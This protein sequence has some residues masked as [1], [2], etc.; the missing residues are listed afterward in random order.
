MLLVL[1]LDMALPK[2]HRVNRKRKRG[3]PS[4]PRLAWPKCEFPMWGVSMWGPL[5][6]VLYIDVGLLLGE[7]KDMGAGVPSS[8]PGATPTAPGMAYAKLREDIARRLRTDRMLSPIWCIMPIVGIVVLFVMLFLGVI[9]ATATYHPTPAYYS[10]Q[11]YYLTETM[12]ILLTFVV[13]GVIIYGILWIYPIYVLITRRNLHFRRV[14]DLYADVVEVLRDI[15]TKTRVDVSG[16]IIL[17]ERYLGEMRM[18]EK[19]KSAA[20]WIILMF[21]PIVNIFAELYVLYFLTKDWYHHERREDEIWAQV[22]QALT[23]MGYWP[24]DIRRPEPIPSRSFFLYFILSLLTGIWTIYWLYVLI[25]DPNNHF[26]SHV[27]AEDDLLTALETGPTR[28][29]M[30]PTAP[31]PA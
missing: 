30:T 22:N 18:E 3:L 19:E 31:G 24:I 14:Q 17:I 5:P 21:I 28:A 16:N 6:K 10:A 29:P 9:M 4:F 27:R 12:S 25:K 23:R 15:S 13:V 8:V 20:L 1:A 2:G 26:K 7:V 11:T